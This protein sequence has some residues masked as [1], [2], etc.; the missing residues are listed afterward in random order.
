MTSCS[1]TLTPAL[2]TETNKERVLAIAIHQ[3]GINDKVGPIIVTSQRLI[4]E[5]DHGDFTKRHSELKT[6]LNRCL[7]E[8]QDVSYC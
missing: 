7:G 4:P 8:G 5:H 1:S 2:E 6:S 3:T